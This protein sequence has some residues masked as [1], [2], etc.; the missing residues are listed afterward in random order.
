[1][2]Y[3]PLRQNAWYWSSL[4][5]RTAGSPAAQI[6]AVKAAVAR[7]DRNQAVGQVRTMDEVAAEATAQPRFRAELVSVFAVLA[8]LVATVG[9][10]G[11]LAF[12]VQQ[13]TRELGLRMA[14]GARQIDIVR[15]VLGDGLRM[16]GIGVMVGLAG[17]SALTRF[18]QSLLF[19]VTPLDATTFVA[20]AG[21]LG[22]AALAASAAPALRAARADPA[23]ALRSE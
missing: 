6:N 12:S 1:V 21:V 3:V 23:S 11:V 20:V 5:V 15:L 13:R 9:V 8:L 17:A 4:V 10:A 14:L 7:A 18:L 16:A 22:A 19:G 2:V